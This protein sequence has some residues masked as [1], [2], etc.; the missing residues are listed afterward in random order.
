M[1]AARSQSSNSG[2]GFNPSTVGVV[3]QLI[4]VVLLGAE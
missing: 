1:P 2:E 3:D 4:Y